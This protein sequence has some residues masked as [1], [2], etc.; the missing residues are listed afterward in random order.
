MLRKHWLV[1]LSLNTIIALT[2]SANPP[3]GWR[4]DGTG[5]YPAAK[6]P[7]QWSTTAN[8]VWKT[9]MP[10]FSNATPIIVGDKLF[11]CSEPS[12]L[13]CVQLS[14]GR[15]LW[16]KSSNRSEALTPE[17]IAKEK[18]VTEAAKPVLAELKP[19]E[20]EY[21]KVRRAQRK[22]RTNQELKDKLKTLGSDIGKLKRQLRDYYA[23]QPARTHGTNGY[24]SATPTSD[25]KYVY[26]VFG[27][28]VAAAYDLDGNRQWLR[29]LEAPRNNSN[30]GH[31]T[32]P[33]LA[34][35]KL[36][37]HINEMQALDPKTG[38]TVWRARGTK[39]RWGSPI[40][41]SIA[42]TDVIVTADGALVRAD[43]GKILAQR[44][45]KLDYCAP[46]V[47]DGIAYFIENGGKAVKLPSAADGVAKPQLL[48]T[49]KPKRERYYA[50]PVLHDGLIYA[51][52]QRSDFSII[53]AAT[54][55][56]VT[57]KKLQLG[58]RTVY[59]SPV[60]AGGHIY[61][62]IDGGV[63]LLLKPGREAVEVGRNS[64]ELFR[65][66][67]VFAGERL[68]IR[69]YKNLYCIGK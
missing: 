41:T 4:T 42:G 40:L 50:S 17:D 58:G 30:W 20:Q 63:T 11:T 7:T 19:L 57:E 48:W 47:H 65:S 45:G 68:Y 29:M 55:E 14:D 28:G 1:A 10:K 25:G 67:P 15:I 12:D 2:A 36:I 22:D 59:P 51:I 39:R 56:V 53:D 13:V 18:Q 9:P 54:G 27:S 69:A 62:S 60:V 3:V 35:D 24:T 21:N 26:V 49:T 32:S 23:A 33:L 44:M 61:I 66:S 52:N 8:V 43:D 5:L 64:L 31:C 37:V 34:G 38:D 6:P 16:S 46:I